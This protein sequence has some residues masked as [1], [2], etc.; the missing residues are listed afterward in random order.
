MDCMETVVAA[1]TKAAGRKSLYH[2]TRAGNLRA[3]AHLD[4]L[5]SSYALYPYSAGERRPE[6]KQVKYGEHAATINAHLRIPE[7]M[8]DAACTLEQFRSILDRHVFFWPT[9]RDC[10]KMLDT[11]T[12]REPDESFAILKLDAYSLLSAHYGA[13]KLSKYDSGSSP[14]FPHRCSYRKSPAMFLQL[15]R[16]QTVSNSVV[17][18][19]ASEI[20]EILVE[21]RVTRLSDYLQ[22]IYI[23][24]KDRQ[25]VPERW[26]NIAQPLIGVFR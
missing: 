15:A 18:A 6:A 10:R 24:E 25:A 21:G 19:K 5:M 16:F 7:H 26:R 1:V 17:P 9:V 20:R 13:V 4:C 14:R 23:E 11:Y 8:M 22:C 2:F 3:M 12:R